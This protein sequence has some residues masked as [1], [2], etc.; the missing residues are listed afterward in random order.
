MLCPGRNENRLGFYKCIGPQEAHVV[1][2]NR[3]GRKALVQVRLDLPK[4]EGRQL[5]TGHHCK[6]PE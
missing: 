4:F 5:V 1:P 3:I 6:C 2:S